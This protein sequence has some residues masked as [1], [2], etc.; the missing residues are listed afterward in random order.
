MSIATTPARRA[1]PSVGRAATIASRRQTRRH[2]A[3]IAR[4]T[5]RIVTSHLAQSVGALSKRQ[6]QPEPS[7]DRGRV[8]CTPALSVA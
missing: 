5:N 7:P 6:A 3:I 2:E 8:G 1:S 4:R